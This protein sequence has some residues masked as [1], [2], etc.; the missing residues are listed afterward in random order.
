MKIK[1]YFK[2]LNIALFLLFVTFFL[3]PNFSQAAIPTFV[4]S[5]G[6]DSKAGAITPALPT[7]RAINDILLLFLETANQAITIPT[8]NGG[9][10]TEVTN[11]PQGTGTAGG[12]G[13]T[14]LTVFWSRYNGT[15]GVPTTS[16]SGNHQIGD[17]L[18][19]RGVT[20]IGNPF[21]VTAGGVDATS[22]TSASIPGTTTTVPDTLVVVAAATNLPS[23][24]GTTNF[25][26]WTNVNL[27]NLLERFDV[28][29]NPGN[30]GGIGVAVGS[31]AVAGAY[32]NTTVTLAQSAAKG[33]MSI[34][35]KPSIT[36]ITTD[37]D[38]SNV[39]IAPGASA[40]DL[41]SFTL[42]TS[43]GT[44]TVT[45]A[46]TILSAGSSGGLSLVSL[47]SDNGSTIYCS[48]A[49][50]V[51]N[52]IVFSS[53]NI[54]VTT[55]QT[56]FKIRVTP[57]THANMPAPQGSTYSVSGK[58]EAF[59][60]TNTQMGTD[61][62]SATVTIDNS[63]PENVI[64]S[65]ATA[66]IL[67][68][69][70]SWTNPADVDFD[71][72]VVL[73]RATS[74]VA[75]VPAEGDAYIVG[76]SIGSSTVACVV[77]S[78]GTSCADSGLTAG[79]AYNY[80][81]FS[82]DSNGNYSV[83]VV[84]TGSPATPTNPAPT[85]TSISPTSKYIGDPSF[86]LTVNGTNFVDGSTVQVNSNNRSTT[87][88]SS[89]TLTATIPDT[90]LSASSTLVITV[91]NPAP[92]GG[93]SNSQNL[94]VSPA[95]ITPTKF[96]ITEA[97]DGTIDLASY[98][99]IQAQN[100]SGVLADTYNQDVTL[101]T[102]G[103][104][105][106][107]GVVNI[108]N[109]I[110][111][112]TISD[113][114]IETVHL[115]LQDSE[116][117]GL[118]ASSTK[119]IYFGP[120]QTANVSIYASTTSMVAGTLLS[121]VITRK[122]RLDNLV[123]AGSET[124]YLNSD[125]LSPAKK[126][127]NAPSGG[128]IV[129][130]VL[131]PDNSSSGTVWYYDEKVGTP[132]ITVSGFTGPSAD[133][134]VTSA[135]TSAF[136]INNP[137]DLV[138]GERLHYE[139]STQDQF[140]N[141]STDSSLTAYLYHSSTA[142]S[143]SFYDASSGGNIINSIVMATGTASTS[144]WFYGDIVSGSLDVIISDHSGSPD[145]SGG[146]ND[147]SDSLNINP[148]PV[149]VLSLNNPGNMIQGSRLGYNVS[150]SDI[151][152]NPV[153][154]GDL[155]VY[156]YH[157]AVGTSTVFYDSETGF[158]LI[159]F[160]TI[161]SGLFSKNF[162]LY[163]ND[164]GSYDIKASDNSSAPDGALGIVDAVDNVSVNSSIVASRFVILSPASSVVGSTTPIT[165]QAQDGSGNLDSLYN[166][167]VTLHTSGDATPGGVVS[168]VNGVGTINI[169]DTKAENVS[170]T[171]ED[172]AST[173]LNVS[174]SAT[175][176]FLP[177][178]TAKFT[179]TGSN[180]SSA[181]ERVNYSLGRQDQ[182]GNQITTGI[183]TVYLYNNAPAGTGHFY[184]AA[185]DGSQII[186]TSISNGSATTDV[187]FASIKAGS[188]ILDA[189]DN[190]SA[191]DGALGIVDA[192]SSINVSPG[193][194]ARLTLND[195][196]DMFNGT[197]LGYVGTRYDSYNNPVT[198]GSA[199]Y[200]LYSNASGTST[201]FY[202]TDIG[203]S[204]I[205]TLGFADTQSTASFWYYETKNGIWTIYLSDNSS[206][207]D[208]SSGLVDGEDSVTVS[209]VPI[210]ATKFIIVVSSNSALLGAPV[211]V[212]VRA[213]NNSNDIDTNYQNDVTL[214]ASGSATGGGKINIIN[215]VGQAIVSDASQETVLLTLEDTEGTSLNTS[216]SQSI[217]F[218][219]TPVF[220]TGGGGGGTYTPVVS[221]SGRAFPQANIQ[222]VAIQ[223]G[224]VPVSSPS[225]GSASGNFSASYSGELPNTA[226]SFAVVLYDKDKHIAQT[227]IFKIGVN[228]QL[229][230]TI[231]MSPTVSLKQSSVTRGTFMGVTGS[232]M[233]RYKI[234][235][236]VDG[237]KAQEATTTLS[238]GLY[239]LAFNTYRL[240]LGEHTLRVRQV[241]IQGNASDYSIEKSF[242]VVRSFVPKA[243]LNGDG[244]VDIADWGIYTSRYRA[245]DPK[246]LKTLDMNNDGSVDAK[247]LSLFMEALN[248]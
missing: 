239:D 242:M 43:D 26:G 27:G 219:S 1:S 128:D 82:K 38:P 200:Y 91:S 108:I 214:R 213:V 198:S 243:D 123:T 233:P 35:L 180:S 103:S 71:S 15:Q 204:P 173:S 2:V 16:D 8:P 80:K 187:W 192:T 50:P 134:T 96:V 33:M 59:T 121:I 138:A 36:T 203:G 137:G 176:N 113:S 177:G 51:S 84:P 62:T 172:T 126:F 67:Q 11:S 144:F 72:V 131:I 158:N 165:V 93:I 13:A 66:G 40:T 162:W 209:S 37:T 183:D 115:S 245:G 236:M 95:P 179:M 164:L 6:Q 45:S 109:G 224:Q 122:D 52:T 189:S 97:T 150:R 148:G 127:Y 220:I 102:S 21:D 153:T 81:I 156:L 133:L 7:G 163:S 106:G 210:V 117:T 217:V 234:E 78:P 4:A 185:S 248:H 202:P 125:S 22:N 116:G 77:A 104:A 132:K 53:C 136:V 147:I 190:S 61:G 54:P 111:T 218:S 25:S 110:G 88:H 244:K 151:F 129:T 119:D 105:S 31:K 130:S 124:F 44:D 118:N 34:A 42:Q 139:V 30:G 166:S 39:S 199:S 228:D 225:S 211:T 157:N 48:V 145:G 216:S 107:G 230:S 57:K 186:S 65:S 197:R 152:G 55:T 195:P 86:T 240:S 120:G 29:R 87:F 99:T 20:T 73:R 182:Y 221:F 196:G 94:F 79:T 114:V 149:A 28:T 235:L 169:I 60:S 188:W 100:N 75:D 227:K 207:P 141:P 135:V 63:S 206:N 76:N 10:W 205:T 64:S 56:I 146:I 208:G 112:T 32:G 98:V 232:A 92:G 238:S 201:S 23:S 18:G 215:G 170:L 89:T 74:A 193:A 101:V 181:G 69:S 3:S 226:N 184:N 140:G 5:G 68:V 237:V 175:I 246:N 58:I 14:R 178:P 70:L 171:L 46:T 241:D 167:S 83:G 223:N 24:N 47:T 85:T 142:T 168:V 191:P 154:L 155:N 19:F 159:N 9:T 231:F 160:L 12:T 143:S 222:I 90:D 17:I 49:D 247:D 174:S 41:D 229:A 212:T 194:T 161:S